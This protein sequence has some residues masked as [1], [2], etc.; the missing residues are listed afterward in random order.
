MVVTTHIKEREKKI[1]A[2]QR[3]KKN[4]NSNNDET[5]CILAVELQPADID[6]VKKSQSQPR[7]GKRH[8][9]AFQH[10]AALLFL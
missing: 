9:I 5:E 6:V 2:L 3:K 4:N 1:V 7:H 8:S 10:Y